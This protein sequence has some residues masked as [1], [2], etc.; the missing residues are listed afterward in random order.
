LAT[1]VAVANQRAEIRQDA[2]QDLDDVDHLWHADRVRAQPLGLPGERK[3]F[4]TF[5]LGL[6]QMSSEYR[7]GCWALGAVM[8]L[9]GTIGGWREDAGSPSDL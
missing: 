3:D 7:F 4:N 6:A 9:I 5:S 8:I 1:R 2:L